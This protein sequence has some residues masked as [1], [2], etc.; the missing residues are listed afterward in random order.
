MYFIHKKPLGTNFCLFGGKYCLPPFRMHALYQSSLA[1][2]LFTNSL[3][4]LKTVNSFLTTL[5][6]QYTIQNFIRDQGQSLEPLEPIL[7]P[8]AEIPALH[9]LLG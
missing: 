3:E 4:N 6:N 5:P 9:A 7:G 8:S 1:M 2:F